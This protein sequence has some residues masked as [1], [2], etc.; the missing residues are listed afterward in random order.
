M[1][2]CGF[3]KL[4][5]CDVSSSMASH[6]LAFGLLGVVHGMD[7][8][9]CLFVCVKLVIMLLEAWRNSGPGPTV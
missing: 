3:P 1:V 4:T 2:S 8:V 7:T 5:L 6:F 9:K